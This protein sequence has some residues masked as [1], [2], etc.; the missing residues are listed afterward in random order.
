MIPGDTRA[1]EDRRLARRVYLA[2]VKLI[3]ELTPRNLVVSFAASIPCAVFFVM[4][5]YPWATPA[6]R[7]SHHAGVAH[8][9]CSTTKNT[10][11]GIDAA[12]ETTRLRGVSS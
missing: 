4:E 3:Y 2:R 12:K 8:G 11:H 7:A 6:V 5:Q 10:A 1:A 9:Y